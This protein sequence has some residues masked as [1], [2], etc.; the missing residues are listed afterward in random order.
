MKSG[1]R[2]NRLKSSLFLAGVHGAER[3]DIEEKLGFAMG[4]FPFRY[5]GIPLAASRLRGADYAPLIDRIAD[6]IVDCKSD[7][8]HRDFRMQN[9]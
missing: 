5:L 8:F 1:L 2:A 7:I 6:L 3:K 4:A 9:G